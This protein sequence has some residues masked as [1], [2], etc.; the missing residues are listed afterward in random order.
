M[1][2]RGW[3]ASW[4]QS[5]ENEQGWHPRAAGKG[6]EE[7]NWGWEDHRERPP[8]APRHTVKRRSQHSPP[9]VMRSHGQHSEGEA[10]PR[11]YREDAAGQLMEG[12]CFAEIYKDVLSNQAQ[13]N[14]QDYNGMYDKDCFCITCKFRKEEHLNEQM[15]NKA[16][17]VRCPPHVSRA[18]LFVGWW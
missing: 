8:A 2:W 10:K 4:Q 17:S 5:W 11:W 16:S 6:V 9:N 7:Q 14:L 3:G 12:V 18:N 15:G 1:S 13:V